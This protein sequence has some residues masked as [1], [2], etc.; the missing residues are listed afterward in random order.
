MLKKILIGLLV[1][2]ILV[3]GASTYIFFIGTRKASPSDVAIYEKDG[4][5][6]EIT[7]CQPSKKGRLIFGEKADKAIVPFGEVW[8]TGAN[9]ATMITLNK[10]ISLNGAALKAGSYE[11]FTIPTA[12][13]W[14]VII[15]S[16]TGQWGA[17]SYK[18]E[19]DVLKTMVVSE[20]GAD[21][22]EMF[23]I[24][25]VSTDSTSAIRMAWDDTKVLVPFK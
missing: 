22:V 7:Y 20:K 16:E 19:S 23:K 21:T 24:D 1:V 8:R 9:S 25:F 12:T 3:L 5:K 11:L 15:N 14:T 6:V 2:V 18:P 10:D 17:F 4:L 13:D